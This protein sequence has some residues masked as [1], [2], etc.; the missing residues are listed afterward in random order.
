M[1][2]LNCFYSITKI[3]LLRLHSPIPPHIFSSSPALTITTLKLKVS[4]LKMHEACRE[5]NHYNVYFG[6]RK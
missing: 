2:H 6:I 4:K 1:R 5:Y 3:I